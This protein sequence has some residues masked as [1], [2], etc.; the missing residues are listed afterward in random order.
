LS[1]IDDSNSFLTRLGI[2]S[3]LLLGFGALSGVTLLAV[4]AALFLSSRV[5][6][7]VGN[8]LET[9]LP[10]SER[11]FRL[12]RAAETLAASGIPL[13]YITTEKERD[14][15]F[16]GVDTAMDNL[17]Q[18]L[19]GL[20][21]PS[22]GKVR[23]EKKVF[24]SL[25]DN[26]HRLRDIAGERITLRQAQL[27]SRRSLTSNLLVFQQ[28]LTF[29]VR[30][31][32]SD[33]DVIQRLM[34]QSPPPDGQ[35]AA[36]AGELSKLLPVA[37]VYAVIESVNARLLAASQD[38]SLA[39]L[40]VSRKV[41]D[42]ALADIEAPLK[43]LSASLGLG[44]DAPFAEL[45]DLALGAEGMI[46]LRER[47]LRLEEES[48][49]L[50]ALNQELVREVAAATSGMLSLGL[51]DMMR[52]GEAIDVMRQQY[53]A[54]LILSALV[55]LSFVGMLMYFHINGHVIRRLTWLSEAM[56][57]VAA[58]RLDI[59]LPPSGDT[60]L[61]RLGAALRQFR[62]T[63]AEARD[64]ESALEASNKR[65]EDALDTLELKAAELEA[66]NSKLAELSIRD[67]L[68]GLFNRR[69]FDEALRV[70]WARAGHGGAPF[71]LLMLDVDYFKR[72]NDRYGHQAGDACLQQIA[73]ILKRHSR[74]AGD[75]AARYGGEE[76]CLLCPYMREADADVL[77]RSIHQAMLDLAI[78]HAGSPYGI[79]TV[80]IG[81]AVAAA[82]ATHSP[83]DVVR[84]ADKALYEAK[85][86]GRNR[87]R[88]SALT[89]S[90]T[91][92]PSGLP[93]SKG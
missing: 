29:R 69:H 52:T 79:V 31:L 62:E 66:A 11:A 7:S 25:A 44:L 35:I 17:D 12:A 67:S 89:P 70:E 71:F 75:V 41:V 43:K 28:S 50:I 93:E 92:G 90:G 82:D 47:E 3:S 40:D 68:T 14:D 46:A 87:I 36:I 27:H 56:Q 32:E 42:K 53:M 77:V 74:R 23:L 55:V 88:E 48:K 64:R 18:A 49:G 38:P 80:S 81:Y 21:E 37:R 61:G 33:A 19:A 76:F 51:D 57:S 6:T 13:S 39:L 5:V 58:G 65:A 4:L 8:L 34:S 20:H 30:I 54:Y 73:A 22:G 85:E 63:T 60:E 83:W 91:H 72:F 15:A 45:R 1:K 10:F 84:A 26:L 86:A 78:P 59:E 2:R 16:R 9:Q 24:A